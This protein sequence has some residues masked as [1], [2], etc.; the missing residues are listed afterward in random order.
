MFKEE[1]IVADPALNTN[2][3]GIEGEF[4]VSQFRVSAR[5]YF[6][7]AFEK[8][9]DPNS[10]LKIGNKFYDLTKNTPINEF[11]IEIDQAPLFWLYESPVSK[12]IKNYY[13]LNN[14]SKLGTNGIISFIEYYEK[15]VKVNTLEEKKYF[16][17]S[18]VN[19]IEH[20]NLN[21]NFY[22]QLL[23]ATIKIYDKT[24]FDPASAT[25]ILNQVFETILGMNYYI[26]IF[27]SIS[28]L[29]Q[30][31]PDKASYYFTGA[32]VHKQ[33]GVNAK[34]YSALADVIQANY[35]PA[36][37]QVVELFDVDITRLQY[38]ITQDHEQLYNILCQCNIVQNIFG[39]NEFA[40]I[41]V[42]LNQEINNRILMSEGIYIYLKNKLIEYGHIE[43]MINKEPEHV[44][45]FQ[46]IERIIRK[47]GNS[48]NLGYLLSLPMVDDKFVNTINDIIGKIEA[49]FESQVQGKLATYTMLIE[50]SNSSIKQ[51]T[52]E[53]EMSKSNVKIKVD[54]IS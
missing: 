4:Y 19:I 10:A 29:K 25:D 45:S 26:N 14:R 2:I 34:F 1:L 18:A 3:N 43:H 7:Q 20:K 30:K 32:L 27:N 9:F 51:L 50:E 40:G 36:L 5:K 13:R 15:W 6:P 52:E 48:H 53:M 35:E 37:K 41:I 42:D 46:T 28:Y 33:D 12:F 11:F 23:H 31:M 8:Q 22:L 24:Y 38:A 16:A 44:L 39:F 47:F 21:K 54:R 17:G 49:E